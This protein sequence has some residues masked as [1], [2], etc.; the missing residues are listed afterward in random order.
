MKYGI[1][2]GIRQ[3]ALFKYESDRDVALLS[4]IYYGP[5]FDYQAGNV[6][7]V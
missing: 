3:V 6:K 7:E 1:Y 5:E 4:L 2:L